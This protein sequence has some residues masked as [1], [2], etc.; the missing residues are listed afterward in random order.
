MRKNS[1]FFTK[2][3]HLDLTWLLVSVYSLAGAGGFVVELLWAGHRASVAAW[4]FLGASLLALLIAAVPIAKARLLARGTAP[5]AVAQAIA[6]SAQDLKDA[7][8]QHDTGAE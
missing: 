4:S 8:Y 7:F 1:M 5:G 6:R 2:E 3:G